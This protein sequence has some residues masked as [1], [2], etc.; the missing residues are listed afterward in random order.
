MG[1]AAGIRVLRLGD[2]GADVRHLQEALRAAGFPPGATDGEFGSGTEAAVIAFQRGFGLLDDGVAGAR[3]WAVLL[4]PAAS[5]PDEAARAPEV[6]LGDATSGMT[7][8]IASRMLPGAH[9]GNIK[10]HLPPVLEALRQAQAGDRPMVL[11]AIASIA[12]EI[13]GFRPV[14]EG[15]SRYN[16]SPDGHPFDLYDNRHDLGNRGEPDGARFKG[17]GFIQLT[18]RANYE[19]IGAALGLDLLGKPAQANDPVI[20][21]RILALF[22]KR[23]ERRIKAALLEGDLAAARRLV[24]GGS[25]GL[26]AFSK[27]YRTG[28][29]LLPRP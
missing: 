2:R 14:D 24:N 27:A 16:T 1:V 21:A 15:I 5:R 6:A 13:A 25:H 7:A 23:R 17:R 12:A 18:G 20:A 26:D 9:L 19:S 28:D 22:L 3:T 8:E 29:A 11:M 10:A 4:A